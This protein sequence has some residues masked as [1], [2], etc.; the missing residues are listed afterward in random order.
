M[1]VHISGVCAGVNGHRHTQTHT[2]VH[3]DTVECPP[4]YGG[5]A[6]CLKATCPSP[7][8]IAVG[9]YLGYAAA[10]L[11]IKPHINVKCEM[12]YR[13]LL[14][15]EHIHRALCLPQECFLAINAVRLAQQCLDPMLNPT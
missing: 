7:M 2:H 12:Q 1:C 8:R 9:R 5:F 14:E 10:I 15:M 3:V 11:A 13:I 4:D 6:I